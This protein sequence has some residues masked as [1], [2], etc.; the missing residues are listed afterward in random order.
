MDIQQRLKPSFNYFI[1]YRKVGRGRAR[2]AAVLFLFFIFCC[3]FVVV[4]IR[5]NSKP[6]E[7]DHFFHNSEERADCQITKI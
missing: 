5:Y 4:F 3:C 1:F 2:G 6:L 7:A